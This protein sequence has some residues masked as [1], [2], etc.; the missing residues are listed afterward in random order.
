MGDEGLGQDTEN[1]MDLQKV[2]TGYNFVSGGSEGGDVFPNEDDIDEEVDED[3]K[4]SF[5]EQRKLTLEMFQRLS[6]FN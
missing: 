5:T 2:D 6:R 1:D 4:E 3:L